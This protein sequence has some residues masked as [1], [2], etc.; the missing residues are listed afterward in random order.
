VQTGEVSQDPVLKNGWGVGPFTTLAKRP[1]WKSNPFKSTEPRGGK[2]S[3]G[4]Y[5]SHSEM[6]ELKTHSSHPIW[7]EHGHTHMSAH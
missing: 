5:I 2:R 1:L 6:Q 3:L 7:G 4:G